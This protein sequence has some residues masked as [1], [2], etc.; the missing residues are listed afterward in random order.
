MKLYQWSLEKFYFVLVVLEFLPHYQQAL[1]ATQLNIV[2]LYV[3]FSLL[4]E[5]FRDI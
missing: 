1:P 2:P 4:S 3:T 5:P